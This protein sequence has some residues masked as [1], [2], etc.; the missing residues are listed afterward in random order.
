MPVANRKKA[1][2]TAYAAPALE[3]AFDIMELLGTVPDG[4]TSSELAQKLGR[5]V[6][7][8]FRIL[9][10]MERRGWLRRSPETDRYS[11]SYH[12]LETAF[13]ASPMRALGV[14]AG[15]IMYELSQVTVQSCHLVVMSEDEGLIVQQ[16]DSPAHSGFSVRLGTRIHIARSASGR[17]LLAFSDDEIAQRVIAT[18]KLTAGE[19]K[20]LKSRLVMI[21][22]RG[23]EIRPSIR[24][25]GVTDISYPIFGFDGRIRA[26]LS[27]PFLMVIDGTQ[28]IDIEHARRRVEQCARRISNGLGWSGEG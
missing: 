22:D 2:K 26:T 9:V 25:M 13:K 11:V 1:A 21:R 16:Q 15:P 4:L 14:I 24:S 10:V 5:S 18:V 23:Y 27:M 3:K 28:K 19:L 20:E 6:S 12:V 8:L 7:E 17:V